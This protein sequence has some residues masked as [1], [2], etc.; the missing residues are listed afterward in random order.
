MD[1][2]AFNNR[3][4]RENIIRRKNIAYV[5]VWHKSD[6]NL[7]LMFRQYC[8]KMPV[9]HKSYSDRQKKSVFIQ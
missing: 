4:E 9:K 3:K 1:E 2:V 6:Y 5:A 7:N 8:E